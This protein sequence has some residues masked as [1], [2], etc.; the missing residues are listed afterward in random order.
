MKSKLFALLL[1]IFGCIGAIKAEVKTGT[2]GENL[3]WS[4]NTDNGV[5]T[6]EGSGA[7]ANSDMGGLFPDEATSVN[8]WQWCNKYW[9]TCFRL[10]PRFDEYHHSK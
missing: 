3:T 7:M 6:I 5:L 4:F 2:C 10:L 8:I 1:A 9:N